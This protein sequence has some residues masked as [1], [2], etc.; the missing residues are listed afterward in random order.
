MN[1]TYYLCGKN[2]RQKKKTRELFNIPTIKKQNKMIDKLCKMPSY[3]RMK[4]VDAAILHEEMVHARYLVVLAQLKAAYS[5][6][7]T[8]GRTQ[9]GL[10]WSAIWAGLRATDIVFMC[11]LLCSH[12]RPEICRMARNMAQAAMYSNMDDRNQLMPW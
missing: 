11:D 6:M 4:I 2:W 10:S 5:L 3:E 12:H 1:K 9:C 8:V 7:F